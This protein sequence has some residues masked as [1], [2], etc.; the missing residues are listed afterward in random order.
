MK[1]TIFYF[2]GTGNCLKVAR[3]LAQ[4]IGNAEVISIPKVMD[5]EIDLSAE[6][7]GLVYPVY[8]FGMPLIIRRFIRKLKAARD[9]YI[10]AVVTCG[11]KAARTL[12]Q[13]KKLLEALGLRLSAGFIVKMPGN[14]TPL[15]EALPL[16]KQQKLFK[17]ETVRIKQISQ[18]IKE[19]KPNKIE[20]DAFILNWLLSLVYKLCSTK[21]P[22]MDKDFWANDLCNGCGIC[23]KVCPV[24]N[25]EISGGKPKW[26]HRCEQCFAC[27]HMCPTEA[28][29]CGKN[30]AGRKRYRHPDLKLSDF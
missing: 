15:Y 29:Q 5:K 6:R 13:N 23:I 28:V 2:S 19:N 20:L 18:F 14:Y 21:I 26:L 30:T 8:M 9:K 24:S 11:G 12:K 1:T 16:D 10:F 17:N 3:D 4:D 25:I 22:F 27:L 7:I